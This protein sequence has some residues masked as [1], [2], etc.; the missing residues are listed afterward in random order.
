[1]LIAYGVALATVG[2]PDEALDTFAKARA[3]DPTSG[4]PLLDAGTVFLMRGDRDRAATSFTDAIAID[5]M[6]AR[7]HNGLGVIDAERHAYDSA[8]A[9]WRRAVELDPHD[10]E[11]LFNLGDLLIKIGRSAE[12]RTYWER[13]LAAV[14]K[15]TEVS[16]RAR[17]EQLVIQPPVVAAQDIRNC[18][19]L[20]LLRPRKGAEW[21]TNVRQCG[22]R[23]IL[24]Q[25]A[26]G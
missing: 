21:G 19:R 20:L 14:P 12:A 17:V 11:T 16:D 13:Y 23:P 6:L 3:A 10:S 25:G 18:H 9:H 8:L 24:T 7:A 26:Y 15:G 22:A 5:P 2:R 4:L 1:M